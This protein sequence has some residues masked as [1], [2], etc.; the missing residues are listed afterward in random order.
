MRP[1]VDGVGAP[2]GEA[3]EVKAGQTL[4]LHAIEGG[5]CRSYISIAGGIDVPDYLGSKSTFTLGLFGGHGGRIL[6]AGDVLKMSESQT[7]SDWASQA[8]ATARVFAQLLGNWRLLRT[9]WSPDF[10]HG[11]GYRHLLRDR[12]EG[13]LQFF[14]HR[15]P[16]YRAEAALGSSG[17]R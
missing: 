3:F 12:L 11:R 10:F 16:A 9:A 15:H 4:K 14:A 7:S 17:W 13:A 6:R 2:M 1:Q 8:P 5:G